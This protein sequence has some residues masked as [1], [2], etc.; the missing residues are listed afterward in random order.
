M[1]DYLFFNIQFAKTFIAFLN[2]KQLEYTLTEE[3]VQNA[4]V[5]SISDN[6]ED[7]LWNKIDSVYDDLAEKDQKLLQDE[8]EDDHTVDTAGIYIQLKNDKTTI[9]RIDPDVMNR[10]L[11]NISMD[12]FNAF[13]EVIVASVERPDNSALCGKD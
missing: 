5:V 12:E 8:L 11:E 1:L 6:L 7:D 4:H 9:A 10:M 13:I 3:T 2:K